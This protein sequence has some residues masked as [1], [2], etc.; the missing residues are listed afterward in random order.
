MWLVIRSYWNWVKEFLS[1]L[2]SE[3]RTEEKRDSIDSWLKEFKV[4]KIT[5]YNVNCLTETLIFKWYKEESKSFR[6]VF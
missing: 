3:N 6:S 4:Q 1:L 5:L 2:S